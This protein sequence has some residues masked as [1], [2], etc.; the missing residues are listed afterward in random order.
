MLVGEIDRNKMLQYMT[1]MD[2]FLQSED[3]SIIDLIDHALE[4]VKT[5][6]HPTEYALAFMGMR[7]GL[8]GAAAHAGFDPEEFATLA[9]GTVQKTLNITALAYVAEIK[10]KATEN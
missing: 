3:R 9:G 10:K 1:G 8:L 7:D 4:Q 5:A 2:A 6:S